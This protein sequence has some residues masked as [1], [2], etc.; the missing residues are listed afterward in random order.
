M[1]KIKKRHY[2]IT[3]WK[4]RGKKII[5]VKT[6]DNEKLAHKWAHKQVPYKNLENV[7]VKYVGWGTVSNKT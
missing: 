7:Q 1:S 5:D 4:K 3:I 2:R 6:F